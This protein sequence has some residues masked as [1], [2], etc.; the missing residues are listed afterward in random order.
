MH[1][2]YVYIIH[3]NRWSDIKTYLAFLLGFRLA[4][5]WWKNELK[6]VFE[7]TLVKTIGL[8]CILTT[9]KYFFNIFCYFFSLPS[10]DKFDETYVL[11]TNHKA[12][13]GDSVFSCMKIYFETWIPYRR[14]LLFFIY[15]GIIVHRKEGLVLLATYHF[16]F[17]V[18]QISCFTQRN[19]GFSLGLSFLTYNIDK[20]YLIDYTL[21]RK[22][23][24]ADI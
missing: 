24:T 2:A 16:F 14:L 8:P 7:V 20:I 17:F 6:F 18:N 4:S 3:I 13:E 23:I 12:W 21:K 10:A 9:K 15:N 1:I 5:G 19:I 11:A 22:N